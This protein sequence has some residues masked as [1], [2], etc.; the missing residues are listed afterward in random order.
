[1]NY[2]YKTDQAVNELVKYKINFSKIYNTYL[3][4][5]KWI[6]EIEDDYYSEKIKNIK[7]LLHKQL[8]HGH[9]QAEYLQDL[10]DYI[11]TKVEYIEDYKYS[12]FEFFELFSDKM[13]DIT[14]HESIPASNS[15][16]YKEYKIDS[17]SEATNESE[18]FNFLRFHSSGMNDFQTEI[19]FEKGRLLFV[20][21][22]YSEALKDLHGFIYSIHMDAE[23]IDFKSLD[24]EDFIITPKNIKENLCHINLNKKSVAHLFRIL[25]EEDFLV[26]DEINENNN[27]LEM[28]RF[29]QNNFSYQNNEN[30][31]TSIHSFNREYSEVASPSSSEVKAHKE[32]IDEFILKL[33]NRKNRLRD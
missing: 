12:S 2:K 23:Y 15:D 28:K 11:W 24:F 1:M 19:D 17:S 22:I 26:F 4:N 5:N 10:L 20:L 31:R 33:Q 13:S 7:N 8:K 6:N 32:F 30:Q 25:L 3:F 21:S 27:R 16:L 29:V 18:L 9:K 14:S